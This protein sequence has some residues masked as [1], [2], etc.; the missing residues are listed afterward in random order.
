MHKLS[1]VI[2]TLNE[3][4]NIERCLKSVQR[5]ADDIVVVDSFS[6]DRTQQICDKYKVKFIQAAWLGY[7]ETK[8]YAN[9]LTQSDWVLSL[10][11]DEALSEELQVKIMD[12]KIAGFKGAYSFNRLTNYCGKWIKHGGWYPDKKIRLF[13]RNEAKWVGNFVHEEL[14]VDKETDIKESP[15]DILHFSYYTIDEHKQRSEKY[16]Q[17]GAEKIAAKGKSVKLKGIFSPIARF[18]QMYI[19]KLGFLDGY[20]GYKIAKITSHEVYLKYKWAGEILKKSR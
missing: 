8:N 11:A 6:T 3:E 10:D 20:Y 19:F 2:I 18:I 7:A 17:L 5:V 4:R 9:L 1:V 15:F 13:N 12:L 16:A 14:V